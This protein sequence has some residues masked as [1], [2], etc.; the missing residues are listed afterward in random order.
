MKAIPE[1]EARAGF[2][3]A[4]FD[5]FDGNNDGVIEFEEFMVRI[6][7]SGGMF[8]FSFRLCFP[9]L[10]QNHQTIYLATYSKS[11]MLMGKIYID[12]MK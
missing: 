6:Y 2:E 7:K 3:D 10:G 12:T 11:M 9:W 1:K 8:Q 4:V 5:V